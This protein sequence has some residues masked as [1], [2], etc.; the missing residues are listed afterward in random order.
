M[1]LS[2]LG[3]VLVATAGVVVVLAGLEMLRE[4]SEAL[5]RKVIRDELTT[6]QLRSLEKKHVQ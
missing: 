5:L 3:A 4:E 6:H 1:I 2:I